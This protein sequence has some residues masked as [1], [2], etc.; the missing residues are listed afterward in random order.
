M[1][2]IRVPGGLAGAV[3]GKAKVD[4]RSGYLVPK[5]EVDDF[6]TAR[7]VVSNS[8][9]IGAAIPIQIEAQLLSGEFVLLNLERPWLM[10]E[11]GFILLKR[12]SVSPA[13]KVFMENVIQ[14]EVDAVLRN[15]QLAD[16][17][18]R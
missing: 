15:R 13:A 9:G 6:S 3:P 4:P 7:E 12:R 2:S 10:P 1:V 16:D 5:V 14:L 18:L 8:N 11:H 17:Y